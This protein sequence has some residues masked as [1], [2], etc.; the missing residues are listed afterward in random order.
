MSLT[1]W[2]KN[3]KIYFIIYVITMQWITL[4]WIK[5]LFRG[6]SLLIVVVVGS[7]ATTM[8]KRLI[9]DIFYRM[10]YFW[11][12]RAS[13]QANER[14]REQELAWKFIEQ[15]QPFGSHK[16]VT[17]FS[18]FFAPVFHNPHDIFVIYGNTTFDS[19]HKIYICTEISIFFL[20]MDTIFYP[21]GEVSL[22]LS[23][24]LSDNSTR[25]GS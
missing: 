6:F 11:I 12:W 13:E 9:F 18:S 21:S 15:F 17:I 14:T 25:T 16:M 5:Y 3:T 19:T 22:F 2:K 1:Q 4:L 23:H 24:K 8:R 20:S 10:T 7:F